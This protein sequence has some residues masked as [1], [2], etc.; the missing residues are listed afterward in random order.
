MSVRAELVKLAV[1]LLVAVSVL[2]VLWSVLLNSTSGATHSYTATFTDVSGLNEGDNVRIAG[3]RV[4]R[5]DDMELHGKLADV[6]F[7]VQSDQTI[8]QNTV[9]EI[10]YQNLI[11]QRYIA[12]VP[13]PGQA[14]ALADGGHIPV[15]RT[16]PSLDLSILLNG[17]QP[18]FSVLKPEDINQLSGNLL[19]VLQGSQTELGPLLRQVDLLT[20][21]IADRDQ[22]IGTVVTNLN[23]VLGNLAGKGPEFDQLLDQGQRLV[24][25]LNRHSDSIF[26]SLDRLDRTTRTTRDLVDDLR[27][28]LDP[29]LRDTRR[30]TQVFADARPELANTLLAFPSFLNSLGRVTDYG[31]YINLYACSISLT[32]LPDTPPIFLGVPGGPQ[33]EVCR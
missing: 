31:S 3:V 30:A 26:D 14:P 8:F 28:D 22:I 17:F 9:A 1:F 18:L 5:V 16:R 33:S 27:P 24:G 20:N 21:N 11:G 25:G 29:A 19:A 7:S 10:R 4:G 32:I 12:L 13:G 6:T 15:D 2:W 23:Q